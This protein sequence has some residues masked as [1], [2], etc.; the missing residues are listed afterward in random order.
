M[1]QS[2]L[3]GSPDAILSNKVAR[4]ALRQRN[5]QR[6]AHRVY[7]KLD[8]EDLTAAVP[9]QVKANGNGVSNGQNSGLIS[10]NNGIVLDRRG[11]SLEDRIASGEFSKSKFTREKALR[12]VRRALAKD[13][14]GPGAHTCNMRIMVSWLAGVATC[15]SPGIVRSMQSQ[16]TN[17]LLTNQRQFDKLE[18]KLQAVQFRYGLHSL[19]GNGSVKIMP[20]CQLQLETSGRLWVSQ[21]LSRCT[22]CS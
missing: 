16:Q 11:A 3:A 18:P 1:L 10:S 14:I 20:A 12:P 6:V 22:N 15:A 7:A 19:E 9:S 17:M 2:Y 8:V 21:C 5:S 13:P 4:T